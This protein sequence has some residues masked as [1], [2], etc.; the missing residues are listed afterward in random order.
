MKFGMKSKKRR[1]SARGS[2]R[3]SSMFRDR[4][5][6]L[7]N[8]PSPFPASLR[9]GQGSYSRTAFARAAVR[10]DLEVKNLD[11]PIL[12]SNG[13][14]PAGAGTDTMTF[15]FPAVANNI[16]QQATS[17]TKFSSIVNIPQGSTASSREGRKCV[18]K[19][20]ELRVNLRQ[21]AAPAA[22]DTSQTMR[23]IIA[24][25]KQCNGTGAGKAGLF[26]TVTGG[27][28]S[29]YNLDNAQRFTILADEPVTLNS[30]A[31]ISNVGVAVQKAHTIKLVCNIPLEFSGIEGNTSEI[32]SNN[33]NF[34]VI[35][36][37]DGTVKI[38]GT[39]RVLF[40]G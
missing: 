33:I 35:G 40:V 23:L 3:K 6:T 27:V 37:G 22:G 11:T 8:G 19:G 31:V 34:W 4:Y 39:A 26:Q 16:Y 17:G 29:L 13:D 32:R 25:D 30:T 21:T 12:M 24:L 2:S 15:A 5:S 36:S 7:R 1:S 14:P 9:P 20:I 18:V 10:A 28:N 38:T